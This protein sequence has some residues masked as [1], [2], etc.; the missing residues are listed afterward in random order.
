M[1]GQD[2]SSLQFGVPDPP[3]IHTSMV[4][5]AKVEDSGQKLLPAFLPIPDNVTAGLLLSLCRQPPSPPLSATLSVVDTFC[6]KWNLLKS[7]RNVFQS[8]AEIFRE[9]YRN[10][11]EKKNTFQNVLESSAVI[12]VQCTVG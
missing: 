11:Q 1:A 5:T 2:A 3:W 12:T 4:L 9:D 8:V 7:L 6:S 10:Y